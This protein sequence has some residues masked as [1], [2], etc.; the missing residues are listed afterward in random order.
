MLASALTERHS[1][2][3]QRSPNR[4]VL[5]ELGQSELNFSTTLYRETGRIFSGDRGIRLTS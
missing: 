1:G 3:L 2:A 4:D 5:C